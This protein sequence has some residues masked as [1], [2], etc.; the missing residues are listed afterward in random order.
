MS[1][2]L[3]SGVPQL[4]Q[5]GINEEIIVP[6]SR[7]VDAVRNV[8]AQDHGNGAGVQML[9]IPKAYVMVV[10]QRIEFRLHER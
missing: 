9:A 3:V 2:R 6:N 1:S 4:I 5:R 10:T 8:P 7:I